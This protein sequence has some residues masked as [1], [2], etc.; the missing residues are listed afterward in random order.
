MSDEQ[1]TPCS[2]QDIDQES[3]DNAQKN[4]ADYPDI[5]SLLT[6]DQRKFFDDQIFFVSNINVTMPFTGVD[7]ELEQQSIMTVS[8]VSR[9]CKCGQCEPV[10]DEEL[11]ARTF[12]A[13]APSLLER[14][15][16]IHGCS[17]LRIS[18]D[19]IMVPRKKPSMVQIQAGDD[20]LIIHDDGTFT[21]PGV[22]VN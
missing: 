9:S 2:I 18:D 22:T 1:H 17:I 20:Q 21:A 13:Y 5:L 19:F 6:E 11:A 3:I 14:G 8:H 16:Q 12:Q 4:M 15:V 7:G 10:T